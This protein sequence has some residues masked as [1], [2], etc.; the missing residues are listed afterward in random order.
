MLNDYGIIEQLY[1]NLNQNSTVSITLPSASINNA[2]VIT[3]KNKGTGAVN[4]NSNNIE[5]LNSS[6]LDAVI[7]PSGGGKFTTLI[8]DGTNWIKMT[9]N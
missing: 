9:G 4:S 8:S 1:Y 7:L 5:P 6:S 3:F 2:M